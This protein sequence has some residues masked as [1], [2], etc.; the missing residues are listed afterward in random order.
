MKKIY[1][2]LIIICYLTA[3][4]STTKKSIVFKGFSQGSFFT[5][6]FYADNDSTKIM[7][8]IDSLLYILNYTASVFDTNSIISK[9]NNNREYIL[10]EHFIKLFNKS[11]EISKL[12]SG[13][14]DITVGPLVNVWGFGFKKEKFPDKKTVDSIKK[15]IGYQMVKIK[16]G[17]IIKKYKETKLD[18]NAIA[19]GYTVDIINEF[20]VKN[21]C[22]NFIIEFAGEVAAKGKKSDNSNWIAGIE[23]PAKTQNEKQN[24]QEKIFLINKSLAT[25]GNYR[26]FYIKD[27]IKFSH[28]I[29]PKTG[30]PVSHNLLSVTVLANDCTTA[31][32]LGTAFMVMGK[33]KCIDFIN[34]MP[35]IGIYLIFDENNI[36][37]TYISDEMKKNIIKE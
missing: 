28:T 26:K 32:A 36:N 24:I 15:Y 27:G 35:S 19:Q 37:K 11:E 18:F 13:A 5:I 30:F 34:T 12:T 16:N 1:L 33:D 7:H 2:F 6:K 14:F 31:D 8:G 21:G 17:K 3:C 10:N 22:N 4:K 20:L 9:V 23:K 25:S 29:D